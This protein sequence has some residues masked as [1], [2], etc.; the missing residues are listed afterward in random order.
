MS[1]SR[2]HKNLGKESECTGNFEKEGASHI[3]EDK[4]LKCVTST[5]SI[6]GTLHCLHVQGSHFSRLQW[7]SQPANGLF[8]KNGRTRDRA[9]G[10]GSSKEYEALIHG[11]K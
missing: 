4:S 1:S 3:Q 11:L 10:N 8:I 2:S 9:G 7:I 5:A 6:A